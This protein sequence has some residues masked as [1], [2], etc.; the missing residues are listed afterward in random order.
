MTYNRFAFT[1]ALLALS[2]AGSSSSAAEWGAIKGRFLYQGKPKVEPIVPNKDE[3]YCS[4]NKLVVE[5]LKVSDKGE[6]ENV[7]VYLYLPTGKKVDIHPDF[8]AEKPAP[9]VLDNKGC[10]FEPHA[11]TLWNI[12][13]LEVRNSDPGLG[14]N[15]N[16]QKLVVNSKFNLQVTND[17][18]LIQK[19][20]KP[21]PIPTEISCN[22]HPWMNSVVLIRDNPY[23]AVSDKEGKFEIKNIPAGKQIFVIWQESKGNL[24]DLK[25]GA[26]KA[27]RKG[28]ITLD[29]KPGK[30]VDLG[31]V[32][33]TPAI[34][35][36]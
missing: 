4:K 15:T 26:N 20:D 6:L 34:L 12:H 9:K 23:M 5:T 17:T 24:K 19:F 18:P 21:E 27:D 2:G 11:M 36:K 22:A 30:T 3:A 14:H 16:G 31:D 29:I 25:V 1:V 8:K 33:V 28:Q 10:R 13:P 32:T 7:F 35:G